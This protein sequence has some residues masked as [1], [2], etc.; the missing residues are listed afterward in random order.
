MGDHHRQGSG[1]G[2]AVKQ[3]VTIQQFKPPGPVGA[4]HIESTHPIPV[5]MGPA[6]S[7]KTVGSAFKGP[8][9]ATNWF[10]VCRDG[11]VRVKLTVLRPTYRDMART[12]LE[13]WHSERL[14]PEKHPWTVEYTGGIDR[15][16]VHKM[17]WKA[18]RGADLVT[19][20]FTAMFAAI[21]DASPEQFAK[22]FETSCVWLN[23]CDL[24]GP[25]IPGLMFS[26]TGRYPS[27]D[28]IAS[29]ELDRVTRERRLLMQQLGLPTQD[30]DVMLPRILWGDCNPPD[31]GNWVNRWL[32]E[33]PQEHKLYKMFR[34]PSGLSPH[35]ENREGKTR[36]SY[37][38]D[39]QTM[40]P[41]DAR[42]FVHGEIGY[43]LDGKP[44]YEKEY[45]SFVHRADQPLKP[46]AGV[47]LALGFDAGGSPAC[48]IG[49]F[50]PS[51][52]LRILREVCAEPGTGAERFSKAVMETLVQHLPGLPVREAFGDPS[53]F[54][55]ADRAN[56]EL[57]W[58]EM[59][60]R[61]LSINIEPAPS[62]EPGLRQDAVRWYLNQR[63]DGVTPGLLVDP[64]CEIILGGFAAHYKLTKLAS[65][66]QTDRL[67]VAKN[68]YS[69]VHDALQYLC[70]GHRGRY[71]VINDA[72]KAMGRSGNV[73]A[74]R[75]NVVRPAD[76][77]VFS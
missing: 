49:Q 23:E 63:M 70:L 8:Y 64:S 75:G 66:G 77:N 10:P 20:D 12:A 26:R 72:A 47:P 54:Y 60:A 15:P 3:D 65:A 13:S 58:M 18:K 48:A 16:V 39:L 24:F 69:H 27:L 35:A 40:T 4:A 71:A 61:A 74:L 28:M 1:F 11:V 5:I 32:I 41:N 76:F 17:R 29:S 36:A 43:A 56:G 9:L 51:G 2:S 6:G 21:G 22:G 73:V 37:E 38:E 55:G 33:K 34:Q 14:F 7:G 46:A 68:E 19:V 59:V 25:R 50:M 30:D 67:A 31:P 52:Q 57:A 45:S 42:R 53:A 44:V 62:N